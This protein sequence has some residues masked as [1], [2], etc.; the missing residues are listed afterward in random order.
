MFHGGSCVIQ[1]RMTAP[2]DHASENRVGLSPPI[3]TSGAW[4]GFKK[5]PS[6]RTIR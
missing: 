2:S 1:W 4:H 5:S 6:K 3:R